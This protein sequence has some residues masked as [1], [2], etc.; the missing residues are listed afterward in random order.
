MTAEAVEAGAVGAAAVGVAGA[1]GRIVYR[2]PG[3]RAEAGGGA[4]GTMRP[5]AVASRRRWL[6][7]HKVTTATE[8]GG[9]GY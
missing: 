8:R 5:A 1:G 2:A 6:P 7:R 4:H 9:G 3:P